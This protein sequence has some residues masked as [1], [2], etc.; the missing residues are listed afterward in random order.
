MKNESTLSRLAGMDLN[1]LHVFHVLYRERS[2]RR[3]A[4]IL[5]VS[6]SAVSHAIGRLRVQLG[7]DLFYHRGRTLAPTPMADRLA[8]VVGAAFAHLEHALSEK[9]DFDPQRDIKRLTVAIPSQLEPW[10]LPRLVGRFTRGIPGVVVLGVRLDRSRMKRDLES[11]ALD[12]ALD[13]SEPVYTNLSNECLFEEALCVVAGEGYPQSLDRAA[14]LAARHVAVSSR[15]RGPSLVDVLLIRSGL[16]RNVAV[17]CQGY[18]TATRIVASSDLLLTMGKRYAKVLDSTLPIRIAPLD[19]PLPSY[20]FYVYWH[21]RRDDD[22]TVIWARS[23]VRD[24]SG[25]MVP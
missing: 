19:I 14:Y 24:I 8:P 3:A 21:E 22:P 10:L 17:R 12:L 16:R 13:G 7:G 1:L 9:R 11:G 23:A 25:G 20:R 15:P 18:D 6:Q 2:V 4:S 5:S